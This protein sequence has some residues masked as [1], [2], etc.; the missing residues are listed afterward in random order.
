MHC[1]YA[2][3]K[4]TAHPSQSRREV[5]FCRCLDC[6]DAREMQQGLRLSLRKAVKERFR[7]LE[8]HPPEADESEDVA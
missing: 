1:S 4:P 2:Q 8:W 3:T 6:K 7:A 5:L